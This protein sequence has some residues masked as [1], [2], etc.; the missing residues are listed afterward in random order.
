M[1]QMFP[2][3]E[4][5]LTFAALFLVICIDTTVMSQNASHEPEGDEAAA[6][7]TN[8]LAFVTKL[9]VQPNFTWKDHGARQINLTSRIIQPTASL[10][11]PFIKSKNPEK[12]Y[13]IY[14]LE[15]PVISQSFPENPGNDATG[16]SDLILLDAV[17]LK[18][19]WGLV[20][21]GPAI[22]IPTMK[23]AQIS[24]GKWSAGAAVVVLNTKTKGF[25]WGLLAQQ[26][27]DFAG[28][29]EM[30]NQNFMI[31][32][33]IVN[34]ILGGG[35]FIQLASI[36]NF[37]WSSSSYNIPVAINMGKAFAKNL[38]LLAGPEY[39]VSGP[40]KGDFTF[41]FQINAMFP[42]TKK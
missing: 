19:K 35:K 13:T 9:Q 15:V 17:V 16:L 5:K 10:G 36:L 8:P 31:F 24:R 4:F 29:S 12:V 27:F 2:T 30:S 40:N 1:S 14:R 41:R 3:S 28:S 7:A 38:S 18:Q 11:L 26:F 37:N 32:Q 6:N 22:T 39:V 23:P 21:I 25:Q 42:P 33:P 20:G 34:K